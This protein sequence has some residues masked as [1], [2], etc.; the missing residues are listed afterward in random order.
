MKIALVG[1]KT[2]GHII[3]LIRLASKIPNN[4]YITYYGMQSSLEERISK[5]N[6][7]PF[8]GISL[9]KKSIFNSFMILL[10]SFKPDVIISTGGYVSFLYLL[11][12]KVKRIPIYLLE[13]NRYMGKTNRIFDSF[14][15]KVFLTFPLEK[16]KKNYLVT[17]NPSAIFK[18]DYKR[19]KKKN[20]FQI[21]VL[22][23]SLGSK[24]L[25]DIAA[26]LS[27]ELSDLESIVLVAGN[28]YQKYKAVNNL[29]TYEYIDNVTDLMAISDVI[30]SRAG[31]STITEIISLGK[32]CLLVPS[33]SV[34]NDHQYL[35]AKYLE[36]K[37]ACYVIDE[38]NYSIPIIISL[39]RKDSTHMQE[40]IRKLNNP[41]VCYEILKN[42]E[43]IYERD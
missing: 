43:G 25:C 35:N 7:I 29:D 32:P 30:I 20:K 31:A 12:G 39:I 16:M 24:V 36:L 8:F 26:S 33:R 14:S 38:N 23:G 22:G 19:F 41:F 40:N 11:I 18:V 37:D 1:G 34:K 15:K 4:H 3:P 2:G 5:R 9:K 17:F 6:E 28:Y 27:K 21:L 10:K 13:E 42:I